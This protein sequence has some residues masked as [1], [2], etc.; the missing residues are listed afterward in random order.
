MI[1]FLP[2]ALHKKVSLFNYEIFKANISQFYACTFVRNSNMCI[3]LKY[4][5]QTSKQSHI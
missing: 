5:A 4:K 1:T 3:A 2:S